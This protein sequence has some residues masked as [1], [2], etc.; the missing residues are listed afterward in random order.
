MSKVILDKAG[1]SEVGKDFVS[2]SFD[3]DR[4]IQQAASNFQFGWK[5]AAGALVGAYLLK[6]FP[7]A[8]LFG[9]F[10]LGVVAG[11]AMIKSE[12]SKNL[13]PFQGEGLADLSH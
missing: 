5:Q 1:S 11:R 12:L 6:K 7:R 8:T 10:S 4:L 9:V 2:P 13:G 3:S